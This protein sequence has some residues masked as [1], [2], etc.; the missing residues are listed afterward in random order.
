MHNNPITVYANVLLFGSK[1]QGC[2]FWPIW[3]EKHSDKWLIS[4]RKRQFS[5]EKRQRK[6]VDKLLKSFFAPSTASQN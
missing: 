6:A 4:N 5:S 2:Y 1:N 3:P